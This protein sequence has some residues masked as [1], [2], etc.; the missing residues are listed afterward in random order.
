VSEV[1]DGRP[2]PV[3][4]LEPRGGVPPVISTRLALAEAVAA[5]AAG[6]GPVAVDAERASGFRYGQRAYLVQIRREDVG[7][8]LIDPMG[9][10]D[11]SELSA[12]LADAEW[13]LHAASQDLP[14]LRETGLR[15]TR[16]FDTELGARLAGF[17]RVGLGTMV[18]VLLGQAL[19]KEHSAVDWSR[20]PLPEPWLRYAALDVEILVDLRDAVAEELARQGKLEWA[21]EEFQAVLDSPGPVPRADPWRRTSGMHRVRSRRQLAVVRELWEAR[22]RLARQRDTAPGR[23][24]PDSAIVA[25]A[26]ASPTTVEGLA[27]LPGWGGRSTRRLA[28]ELFPMITTALGLP[29][30]D[31]PRHSV[32]GDGPPPPNRWPERDPVA[33]ARLGRARAELS[34]IAETHSLPTENLLSPDVVRRLSW[35]PPEPADADSV[36]AYLRGAG[37]RSWQVDLSAAALAE[38]MIATVDA[39]VIDDTAV[40]ADPDVADDQVAGD[41]AT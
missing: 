27:R 21:M 5:M 20:R 9:V 16:I 36:A 14:S 17:E 25:A 4:L 37:A 7:T 23:V 6:S 38:A 35:S 18:E 34:R 32:P 41:A 22:D 31:L 24:L 30:T 8:I 1:V 40:D 28:P 15:P 10:P 19:A 39:E 13:V 3:P 11:L 2:P 26:T 29:E 12:V 33:A